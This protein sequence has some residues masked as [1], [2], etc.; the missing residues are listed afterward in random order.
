MFG[1]CPSPAASKWLHSPF[2]GAVNSFLWPKAWSRQRVAAPLPL[3]RVVLCSPASEGC[4]CS[5]A[6]LGPAVLLCACRCSLL[7]KSL[8]LCSDQLPLLSCYF[9]TAPLLLPFD[10]PLLAFAALLAPGYP[11]QHIPH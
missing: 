10:K 3:A 4:T 8:R 2:M 6:R 11:L 9:C 1:D 5:A 7:P